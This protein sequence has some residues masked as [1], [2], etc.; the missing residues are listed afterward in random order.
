MK[1]C[2]LN[3]NIPFCEPIG[4]CLLREKSWTALWR[5]WKVLNGSFQLT[6]VCILSGHKRWREPCRVWWVAMKYTIM[7]QRFVLRLQVDGTVVASWWYCRQ[8]NLIWIMVI[9]D[10]LPISFVNF[11]LSWHPFGCL[12]SFQKLNQAIV[13]LK[14]KQSCRVDIFS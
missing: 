11:Y 12:I 5:H 3:S 9:K 8:G 6:F 2:P 10:G 7:D 14:K 1:N 4:R 13:N